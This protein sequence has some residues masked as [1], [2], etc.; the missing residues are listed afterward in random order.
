M[1]EGTLLHRRKPSSHQ[2]KTREKKEWDAENWH[3]TI[4]SFFLS[5]YRSADTKSYTVNW[6]T[7]VV[8]MFSYGLLPYES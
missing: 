5:Q 8:K 3:P 4:V 2:G 6:E 7:F 1:Q